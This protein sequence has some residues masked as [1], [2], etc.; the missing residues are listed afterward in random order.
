ML[1]VY[2]RVCLT[3][4]VSLK[5]ISDNSFIVIYNLEEVKDHPHASENNE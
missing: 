4:I 1:L 5:I 3:T 2:I